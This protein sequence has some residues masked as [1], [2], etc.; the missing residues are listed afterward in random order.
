MDKHFKQIPV[1]KLR[2]KL[3]KLRQQVQLG[4]LRLVCTYY[5]EVLGF[6]LPLQDIEA[7][8]KELIGKYGEM[9]LTK[10]CDQLTKTSPKL[11][12][13]TDCI[14]V[15][16]RTRRIMAFLSPRFAPYLP[17]PLIGSPNQIVFY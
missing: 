9:P 17:L 15:T 14:Y 3:P 6:L 4:N 16:Y 8:N 13:S 7:L 5:G 12:S 1:S 2:V 10:F 11:L